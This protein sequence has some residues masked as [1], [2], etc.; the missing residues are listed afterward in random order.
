MSIFS[1]LNFIKRQHEFWLFMSLFAILLIASASGLYKQVN[2][3]GLQW[4]SK[5]NTTQATQ[6]VVIEA[7]N[8]QQQHQQLANIL[9]GY[10]PKAIVF[11][12]NTE[13]SPQQNND[14]IYYPF[15]TQSVC[16]LETENWYGSAIS[17][18]PPAGACDILWDK[19]FPQHGEYLNKIIDY[20]LPYYSLPKFSAQRVL[21]GDLF[22]A[23]LSEKV[24][25]VAQHSKFSRLNSNAYFGAQELP[26]VY[27]QAFIANSFASDSFIQPLNKV[28]IIAVMVLASIFFLVGYQRNATKTNVVI[29]VFTSMLLIMCGI[30]A[31]HWYSVLLPLGELFSLIWLSL[32]WVFISLKWSEEENLKSL[33]ALIQQR[34]MGRY[35]PRHFLEHN[36]PWDAIIQLVNQQL[37]LKRSIFLTRL[38]G[39]HRVTEIRAI[40]CQLSDI[41]EM[42]R[43]YERVPYSDAIKAF[44][45]IKITRPFFQHLAEDEQQ[46]I[47]PLMY[48]GDVRGFWA[49]TV[50]PQDNFDEQAFIKNVNLFAHQIG[51]L[52]FH[53]KV[54]A[55]EQKNLKSTLTRALTFSLKEP[56]SHKIKNA[57]N[58]MDQKL[59][60][61]EHVFNQLHSASILYN[62]FGQIVQ[63]N[64]SLERFAREHK[65]SIFDMSALDLLC[66]CTEMDSEQAKGK[67]RYLTLK[68]GKIVL[69]V[70]L[71]N[72]TYLL[73]IRA[74]LKQS[75][76]LNA[77][78]PFETSGVL[79]EFIDLGE[80]LSQL[81]DKEAF[82]THLSEQLAVNEQLLPEEWDDE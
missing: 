74:L 30:A 69:P 82:L 51:E 44:G 33:I 9:S 80:Q 78:T 55:A 62:L 18:A 23:Q 76:S 24:I 77:S 32:I 39:D 35:L 4:F 27:L 36:E 52:L 53:Y 41:L 11:F 47:A 73:S 2:L 64:E 72:R 58:E 38:E 71:D 49:L 26:P 81:D 19:I 14:S 46:Y 1:Q 15:N 65:L 34:M 67:L 63:V 29:A 7:E 31:H 22:T 16:L 3:I 79:F 37:N 43:D 25:L 6:V 70:Y 75:T 50:T 66:R 5:L 28:T 8:L 68:R 57:I 10:Q 20:S 60:S 48:A 12:A 17:L 54:F 45:A 13:L 42:R 61:L 56:L 40:H 59:T 21:D